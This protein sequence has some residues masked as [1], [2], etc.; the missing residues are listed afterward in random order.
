MYIHESP[1]WPDFT[2]DKE[3]VEQKEREALINL[4]YLAGRFSQIGFDNKLAAE[5]ETMTNN[6]INEVSPRYLAEKYFAYTLD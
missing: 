5:V 3:I 1:G 4:G 2:W 6:V